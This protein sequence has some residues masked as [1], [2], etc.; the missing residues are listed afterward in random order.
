MGV[1][2]YR[3]REYETAYVHVFSRY[4]MPFKRVLI[5]SNHYWIFFG[6]ANANELYVFPSGTAIQHL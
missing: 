5:N 2:H 4:S 1:L 6:L 3:K